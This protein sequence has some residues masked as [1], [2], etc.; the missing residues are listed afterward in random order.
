MRGLEHPEKMDMDERNKL[1]WRRFPAWRMQDP[2]GRKMGEGK[3]EGCK[4]RRAGISG[5]VMRLDSIL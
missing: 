3:G 2:H 5:G 1:P 4:P